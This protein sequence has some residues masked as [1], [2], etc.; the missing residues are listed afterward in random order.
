MS[1]R[2]VMIAAIRCSSSRS[3]L[4]TIA[5]SLSWN[6]PASAPCSIST[7][8]S[9][10]VTV[11]SALARAP[12]RRMIRLDDDENS[13][14]SGRATREK[15]AIGEAMIAAIASGASRPRRLGTSSPTT[16]EKYVSSTTTKDSDSP[17]A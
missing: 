2:C 5:C 8:I 9:S 14:T 10:L 15:N 17:R 12:M 6:T 3:T 1:L 4:E 7:L 16:T 13:Q 11:A